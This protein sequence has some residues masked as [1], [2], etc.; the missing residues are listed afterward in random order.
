MEESERE[1]ERTREERG[2]KCMERLYIV[3]GARGREKEKER[4]AFWHILFL[5]Q[6]QCLVKDNGRDREA[7][8]RDINATAV[9]GVPEGLVE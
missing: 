7:W 3:S 9:G 8:E 5:A 2:E 4:N 6:I 1:R